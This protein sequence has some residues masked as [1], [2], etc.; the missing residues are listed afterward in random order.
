MNQAIANKAHEE[1]G[2]L[3]SSERLA[4]AFLTLGIAEHTDEAESEPTLGITEHTDEAEIE[5]TTYKAALQSPQ[6]REWKDAMRHEW[7]ALVENHTF[8]IVPL[9]KKKNTHRPI[10]DTMEE[11]IGC[12]WIYKRKTNPDGST[13][14]KA[15]LVIKG[16]EQKEGIDYNETYAPVSKMATF[17]LVLALAA[18]YGWDVDHMDVV[19]AFL[20]PK[21]DRDNIHMEMPLGMDWLASSASI[22]NGSSSNGSAS[23]G[24]ASNGSASNGSVSNRSALIL[25]KAL[26]GLKQAP[27][28]WY[29]DI[30]GYLQSIGFRQSAEDPNLYIQPGVLLVLYVDDLLIAHKGTEGKGHQIKQ[31]LQKKYK[32]CDLGA[33]RRFL[34]I[35][36][37]KTEDGGFSICQRDYINTIIRRFGLMEAKP[38]KS[39]LEHQ[40]DLANTHCED[41]PANRKEYLSMVG[42]LMY[43]ALGS[44]PDI[45]YSVTALSRYNVEPLEMHITA[46]KRVL[47]YLKTT[48]DL[49]IHYQRTHLNPHDRITVIGYTD[50]DW[51][52]NLTTR[53]SVGGCLFGLG[54]TD[55]KETVMSGLIHWQAKSQS[56]VALSTLEAEYI[57]ASH[58]TRE[59]LWLKRMFKEA[60]DGMEVKTFDEPVPIGCDNQGAIKLIASGVVRQK[61]K[62]IDVKYHHVHDEQMKGSVKFQYVTSESNPADLLTKPLAAPRHEQLVRLIGLTPLESHAENTNRTIDSVSKK[63]V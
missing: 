4:S 56:V 38:A 62:H 35:E 26:Y 8:D 60:A 30:D 18:Q 21:I 54:T 31:L 42:S 22:S 61:S 57:A 49:R 29:E 45:A 34:G 5:P 9:R 36:I 13:R 39:P 28:L 47:R 37:E 17:R 40:T 11:P 6:S 1:G 53:K 23:N 14:Y 15:R 27:R 10:A 41:K 20:N 50:S 19:T 52:G 44:R 43:A 24:S 33:A 46:A 25:R 58:A 59:S 7:Q 12:K 3:T 48:S 32:M 16:Y 55:G 2:D 51:A 63:G